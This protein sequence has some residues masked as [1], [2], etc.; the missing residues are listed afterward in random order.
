[1]TDFISS[2]TLDSL[3]NRMRKYYENEGYTGDWHPVF[4]ERS[5]ELVMFADEYTPFMLFGRVPGKKPPIQPIMNWCAKYGINA[6]PWA[7]RYNIGKNGTK[8]NNFIEKNISDF[9]NLVNELLTDDLDAYL[10]NI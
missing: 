10:S 5:G 1:M 2:R 4:V 3:G 9:E 7:I 6:N 8:G